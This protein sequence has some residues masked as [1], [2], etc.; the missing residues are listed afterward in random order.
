MPSPIR[1]QA[2]TSRDRIE[3][4]QAIQRALSDQGGWALD[5]QLLSNAAATINV[6]IPMG[7]LP[8]MV[9]LIREAGVVVDEEAEDL[10]GGGVRAGDPGQH[11][12]PVRPRGA[13]PEDQGACGA[14]VGAGMVNRASDEADLPES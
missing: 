13:G 14:R 1:L 2:H 4:V 3:A 7:G 10:A 6:E 5:Y 12:C 9:E 11:L 8:G